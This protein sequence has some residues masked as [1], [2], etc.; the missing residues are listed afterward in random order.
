MLIDN[1][2]KDFLTT[3]SKFSKKSEIKGIIEKVETNSTLTAREIFVL[4]LE[5][6]AMY[7]YYENS[8]PS[9]SM[10]NPLADIEGVLNKLTK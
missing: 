2:T 8:P 6:G 7:E 4:G 10:Y 3:L 1:E 9:S 5:L